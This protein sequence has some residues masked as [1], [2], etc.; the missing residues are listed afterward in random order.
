MKRLLI[1]NALLLCSLLT[2]AQFSGT[3]S[4]SQGVQY[5]AN[6]DES[7]CY[8]SG[9]E[10]SYSATIEIP[11]VYEGC[12]VTSIGES[13][14]YGCSGLTS[15]AI[16]E[17]VTSIGSSAFGYCRGL[18]SITIPSSVTSIG[19]SAFRDCSGLTSLMIPSSVTSI[20]WYAFSNCSGLTSVTIPSGVTSIDW[21]AFEGCSGL[22]SMTVGWEAPLG[23]DDGYFGNSN[24]HN[25]TLYVPKGTKAAYEAANVWKDFGDIK[26]KLDISDVAVSDSQGIRYTAN[27]DEL[28]CYVSGHDDTYSSDI[29]IPRTFNGRYVT[30][31]GAGAFSG[32]SD[33][34]SLTV[35]WG[36]PIAID[37]S[38]FEGSNCH[39]VK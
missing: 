13:A 12:T 3:V 29:I 9:H 22:T 36:T 27:D 28:T 11:Q 8:V 10:D 6:D 39:N 5:T 20:G 31:I 23:I 15:V 25:A 24:Y 30:S 17:G 37:G 14:F 32:C 21:Y 19:G 1:F 4:D 35:R 7:T 16:P 18:T 34:T 38:V 2:F 33:L 26:E